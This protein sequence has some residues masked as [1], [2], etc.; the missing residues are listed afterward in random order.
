MFVVCTV[1]V[2]LCWYSFLCV[3]HSIFYVCVTCCDLDVTISKSHERKRE[4]RTTTSHMYHPKENRGTSGCV[5]FVVP[6][7][8]PATSTD[9]LQLETSVPADLSQRVVL[10]LSWWKKWLCED[11]SCIFFNS[12]YSHLEK[13]WSHHSCAW[14]VF[15]SFRLFQIRDSSQTILKSSDL[16]IV[17]VSDL[18]GRYETRNVVDIEKKCVPLLYKLKFVLVPLSIEFLD[19]CHS[20]NCCL[21]NTPFVFSD[22]RMYFV[23][24]ILFT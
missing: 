16:G 4:G 15:D 9:C 19:S 12:Q 13:F 3:H 22:C 5:S 21:Q 6:Y 11:W 7:F 18:S 8:Q 14:A 23:N 2:S 17:K 10:F 1:C 20:Q 24:L